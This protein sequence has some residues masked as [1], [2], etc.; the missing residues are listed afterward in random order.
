MTHENLKEKPTCSSSLNRKYRICAVLA[1][2]C[3]SLTSGAI[4]ALACSVP[5]QSLT[6]EQYYSAL[7]GYPGIEWTDEEI[8]VSLIYTKGAA[9]KLRPVPESDWVE[10][11]YTRPFTKI[12]FELIE[13]LQGDY[14]KP[15]KT[16]WP[17]FTEEMLAREQDA[18][19]SPR[20]FSFWDLGDVK[21]A[22]VT[23]YDGG[24]MCGPN[25]TQ[26]I[27]PDMYYLVFQ[28]DGRDIAYEPVLT[29]T[30]PFIEDIK[31]SRS[32]QSKGV[33][34]PRSYFREMNGYVSIRMK[35]C[36]VVNE[37]SYGYA[38]DTDIDG[39]VYFTTLDTFNSDATDLHLIDF[40]AYRA[41]FHKD[42]L[43]SVGDE[44][45]VL[46]YPSNPSQR[47]EYEGWLSDVT[48]PRHRFLKI[49]GD[50]VSTGDILSN[51]FIE[52]ETLVPVAHVKSW[53]REG[54]N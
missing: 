2:I 37:Y 29:L 30:D 42:T 18:A 35:S 51:V 45:L 6:G 48:Y 53:I 16:W 54:K 26:T 39:D 5:P 21:S 49:E 20:P 32:T 10:A 15:E 25:T 46:D 31:N 40:M 52:P 9:E 43:C 14:T 38:I 23:G 24:S 33:R 36:P 41:Y 4:T 22:L 44:Y 19:N 50:T 27:A 3:V 11:P 13:I 1:G 7:K 12:R 28:K 34:S 8:S 47:N 17:S